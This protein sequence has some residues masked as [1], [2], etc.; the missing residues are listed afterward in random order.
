MPTQSF[1]W[2]DE[3]ALG[4][5]I[6]VERSGRT[7]LGRGRA[8]LLVAIH[9]TN[10]ISAA[11]REMGMSYRHA[12]AMVQEINERAGVPLVA[13]AVGGKRGGGAHLTDVGQQV[14]QFFQALQSEIATEAADILRRTV[15]AVA[16]SKRT[17][18]IGAIS[19]QDVIV[20]M[21]SD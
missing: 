21:M 2:T 7:V 18:V 8:E 1:T 6:W 17:Q 16:K 4:F 9:R 14:V 11:A 15:K 13:A 5:R 10:S 19:A 12:W 20:R 3:W